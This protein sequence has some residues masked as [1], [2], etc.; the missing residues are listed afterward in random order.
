MTC[1]LAI[2][3]FF[4]LLLLTPI[5]IGSTLYR[6]SGIALH[7]MKEPMNVRQLT[8]KIR[9]ERASKEKGIKE[10]TIFKLLHKNK[11]VYNRFLKGYS[12]RKRILGSLYCCLSGWFFAESLLDDFFPA[13]D[14]VKD[15]L[16]WFAAVA[17]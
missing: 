2:Y 16:N 13:F 11:L 6:K 4:L 14:S 9:S 5:R 7:A 12:Q 10:A 17:S 15:F 1:V 8:C 3:Q